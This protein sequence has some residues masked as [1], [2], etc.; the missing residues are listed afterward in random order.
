MNLPSLTTEQ[1]V[2]VDRLM[3]EEYGILLIQMMENAGRHLAEQAR[4]LRDDAAHTAKRTIDEASDAGIQ[5]KAWYEKAVDFVA[6]HWDELT[7]R[8]RQ[9]ADGKE[10]LYQEGMLARLMAPGELM[11][12]VRSR[13]GTPLDGTIIFSGTL[14]A[15]TG[16]FIY[17]TQ[18]SAELADPKLNRRLAIEYDIHSLDAFK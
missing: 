10:I 11:A 18:L 16:G 12:F 7:L 4:G 13:V 9:V 14:A 3:I 8:C 17:G 1:M 2:E 6:D 5:N 15:L